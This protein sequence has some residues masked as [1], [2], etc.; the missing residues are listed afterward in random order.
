MGYFPFERDW[1][2]QSFLSTEDF[3]NTDTKDSMN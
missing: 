3:V 2:D 1:N